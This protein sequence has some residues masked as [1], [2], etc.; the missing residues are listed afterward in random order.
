MYRTILENQ[1]KIMSLSVCSH[2]ADLDFQLKGKLVNIVSVRQFKPT[3]IRFLGSFCF[4]K[5]GK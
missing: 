5:N 3:M 4:G 1:N 2:V